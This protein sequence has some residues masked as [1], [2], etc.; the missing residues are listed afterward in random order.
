MFPIFLC[1][2]L[3]EVKTQQPHLRC[4]KQTIQKLVNPPLSHFNLKSYGKLGIWSSRRIT[5]KD[6]LSYSTLLDI[7]LNDPTKYSNEEKEQLL[8]HILTI[9][10]ENKQLTYEIGWD[11]P[12]LLILY[13]DSDYEFNGPIRDS[14]GV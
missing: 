6:F 12:Q 2:I 5:I 3:L 13:V 14:W 10:S 7:Y 9:L 11:L 8:G 1:Q 4:Q